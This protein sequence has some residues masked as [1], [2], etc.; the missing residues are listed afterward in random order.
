MWFSIHVGAHMVYS[1][2]ALVRPNDSLEYTLGF[3]GIFHD[4]CLFLLYFSVFP[5][6]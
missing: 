1:V 4:S 3:G 2:L 6:S 5:H